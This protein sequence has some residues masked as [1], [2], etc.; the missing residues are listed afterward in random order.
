MINIT[1]LVTRSAHKYI[2][3]CLL[4]ILAKSWA[5]DI[6]LCSKLM[7]GLS[8]YRVHDIQSRK[9]VLR[10]TLQETQLNTPT[11]TQLNTTL[12]TLHQQHWLNITLA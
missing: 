1:D 3:K 2:F 4:K 11:A 7:S 6:F 8:H 9:L 12:K 5:E 10:T